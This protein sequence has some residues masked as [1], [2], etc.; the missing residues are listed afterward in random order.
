MVDSQT[1]RNI[2]IADWISGAIARYFEK[3]SLGEESFRILKNNFISE[4]KEFFK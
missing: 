2:Q 1:N 4:G 3:G